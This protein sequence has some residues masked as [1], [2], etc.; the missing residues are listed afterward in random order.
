MFSKIT[1]VIKYVFDKFALTL[2]FFTAIIVLA[3][4]Y[5]TGESIQFPIFYALPV[6]M[7]SWKNYK[8]NIILCSHI[9]GV[10]KSSISHYMERRNNF[11][12]YTIKCIDYI[13]CF[14]FIFFLFRKNIRTKFIFKEKRIYA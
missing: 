2:S 3:L 9:Y 11:I 12:L 1:S 8:K 13:F 7:L 14:M 5:F 10:Y 4:D 6:G